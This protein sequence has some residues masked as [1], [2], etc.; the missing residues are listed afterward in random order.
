MIPLKQQ[1]TIIKGNT[2]D[3]WGVPIPGE[4]FTYPCRI[5]YQTQKV[6]RSD[7][8]EVTASATIL[9]KG[10]VDVAYTDEVQ[11]MDALHTY[12]R[13]PLQIAPLPD[14]SGKILFTKVVV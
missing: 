8:E 12:K 6:V 4:Q 5:D 2:T 13:K 9:L 10:L 1:V 3:E 11:W 7:G 14:I